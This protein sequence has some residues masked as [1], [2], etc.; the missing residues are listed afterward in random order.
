VKEGEY[1]G[2]MTHEW[3]WINEACSIIRRGKRDKG[4]WWRGWITKIL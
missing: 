3:K 2:N 4:G 1:G